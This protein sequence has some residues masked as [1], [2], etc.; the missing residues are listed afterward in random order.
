MKLFITGGTGLIGSSLCT[1]LRS[2]GHEIVVASA[3]APRHPLP[4]VKYIV[5][6][7]T[8]GEVPPVIA[9]CDAII[10]LAGAP[11]F[12]RWTKEYKKILFDSRVKSASF[13]AHFL[14]SQPQR[15]IIYLSASAVGF[16]GDRGEEILEETSSPGSG[17]LSSLCIEWEQTRELFASL[18]MRA[19]SLRTPPVLSRQ[20]GFLSHMLPLF[21]WGLGGNLGHGEEWFP[22][23]HL[24]DLVNIYTQALTD[25]RFVGV[26]N[27]V[28]P[29]PVRNRELTKTLGSLLKRPTLLPIP[30]I[31]LRIVLGELATALL[32]SERVIPRFLNEIGFSFAYPELMGALRQ[33]ICIE[34]APS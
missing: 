33:E 25:A 3:H 14:A 5:C 7:L 22:W 20:G 18:G 17:F 15:P 29:Q 11:I 10:H 4:G 9:K 34:Q 19:A 2:C 1:A 12:Q 16:Y 26:I 31:I 23:I 6:D 8:S 13:M 28:A 24:H 32:S 27:A 30:E 21:R